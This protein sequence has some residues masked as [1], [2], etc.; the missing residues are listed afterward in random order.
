MSKEH[1]IIVGSGVAGLTAAYLLRNKYQ[2]TLI[3]KNDYIG[4]HTNTILVDDRT[5]QLPVDTGFIVMNHRNYPLFTELLRELNVELQNS[6]MSFGHYDLQS[7]LYYNTDTLRGLFAQRK[8]I[9]S[10]KFYWLLY[11]IIRFFKKA[12]NDLLNDKRF[13]QFRSM[14]LGDYL[15]HYGFSKHFIDN[16]L[17]PMGSAIWSTPTDQMLDFPL[18]SFLRFYKNHGLL[19]IS[20]HPQWRTVVGGSH[21]YVKKILERFTGE[22]IRSDG[23]KSIQR[24]DDYVNVI[25][26]SGKTIKGDKV[27]IAT[28]AD[29]ALQLLTDPSQEEKTLLGPWSYSVN[30]TYLHTDISILPPSKDGWASWNFCRSPK[31]SS[32][33]GLTLTY[34]MNK[35]QNLNTEKHYLVT[36]NP[37]EPINPQKIIKKIE[38][39]HPRFNFDS[40]NTQKNLHLISGVNRTYYCGSY[41]GNGFHEDAVRS[42][43]EICKKLG[44]F[45]P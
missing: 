41:H 38:Y 18:L 35:L 11:E 20:D 30:E 29:E 6:N 15:K 22:I 17:V 25:L 27:V 33:E 14:T 24:H 10:P 34:N 9:L 8:N 2:L 12:N 42:G 36:L 31:R 3:E 45:F 44:V 28:H 39:T 43:V 16:Y 26:K 5:K 40:I 7:G 37:S 23:A 32:S 13:D 21:T 19:S 1:V 4:G